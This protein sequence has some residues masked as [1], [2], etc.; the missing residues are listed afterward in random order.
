MKNVKRATIL[1]IS[2]WLLD[3]E[4]IRSWFDNQRSLSDRP[5]YLAPPRMDS[6]GAIGTTVNRAI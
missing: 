6:S 5:V 1:V 2:D 4:W 3:F